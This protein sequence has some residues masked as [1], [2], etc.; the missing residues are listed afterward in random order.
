LEAAMA[1]RFVRFTFAAFAVLAFPSLPAAA[2]SAEEFYKGRT[3][4]LI[5]SFGPGGLNDIAGRLVA[6]HLPRFIPGQP[7]VVAQNMPGAGGL[8]A[9]N[10]L[11]NV[12]PQD[13]SVF[14]QLDRSVA[15][16]GLRGAANVKFDPLKFTWLG[17]LSNYGNEAY[18]LWVNVSHPAKTVADINRLPTPTRLGAVSGGTNMMMSLVAKETLGL[19]VKVIRGYVSGPAVWLAMDRGEVDGQTIGLTSVMAEHPEK[20]ERREIRPLLQF[21]RADRLS[22]FPDLPTARELAPTPEARAIVEF[23]ELPFLTSL[24]YLAPPN[25]PADRARA[26]QAAFVAMSRDEA[27]IAEA[28]KRRV[29]L[30]PIDG[31]EIIS[32]LRRSAGT[33]RNVIDRF[34]AIL[35]A[36]N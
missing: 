25:L 4:T 2:Q 33:P 36:P 10:H 34:N 8:I 23:A 17:S 5:I 21:G 22:L 19:N 24:P 35:E 16:S 11:Y 6:Q 20:W 32:V 1:R 9:A 30:S 3:V 12:A 27:F 29:E 18:L 15:Q 26:L 14:A 13:G 7:R 28:G 31:G